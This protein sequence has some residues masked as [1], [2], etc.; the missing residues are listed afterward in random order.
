[1]V[2]ERL[3][4]VLVH[5]TSLPSR[6]GIGDFGPVAYNLIEWLA[7][8]KQRYSERVLLLKQPVGEPRLPNYSRVLEADK[9]M[10]EW[11]Q[12]IETNS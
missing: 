7:T 4:G 9:V 12:R 6:G 1:M 3:S 2:S 11:A 8:A 5:V 10:D